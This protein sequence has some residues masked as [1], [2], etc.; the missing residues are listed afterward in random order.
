MEVAEK[1]VTASKR[2]RASNQKL[3]TEDSPGVSVLP[4]DLMGARSKRHGKWKT[5]CDRQFLGVPRQA[6]NRSKQG[7]G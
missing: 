7:R 3:R 4:P 2:R 5:F 6:R 1:S